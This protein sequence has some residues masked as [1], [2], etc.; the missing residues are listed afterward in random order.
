M[1]KKGLAVPRGM[2]GLSSFNDLL[3][4][5]ALSVAIEAKLLLRLRGKPKCAPG[6][7]LFIFLAAKKHHQPAIAGDFQRGGAMGTI[8]LLRR[9]TASAYLQEVHGL[10]RAVATLAKLAVTGCGPVFRRDG[11][12]P[13]YS[14]DDLDAWAASILE[15]SDA[16]N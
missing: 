12:V 3:W 10:E 8:K 5:T 13:L 6:N 7:N 1:N 16:I 4:Q 15:R 11:R 9:K 2:E 14:T